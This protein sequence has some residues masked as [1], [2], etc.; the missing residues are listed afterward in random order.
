M[1]VGKW[2]LQTFIDLSS[3]ISALLLPLCM[4]GQK[5]WLSTRDLTLHV[6]LRKLVPQSMDSFPITKMVN[7]V[8]VRLQL[9]RSMRIHP[10]FYVASLKPAKKRPLVPASKRPPPQHFLAVH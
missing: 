10:I 9:P 6:E 7:P 1:G 4:P 8:A 2:A 3:E 5:V